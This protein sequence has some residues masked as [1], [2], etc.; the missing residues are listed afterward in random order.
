MKPANILLEVGVEKVMLTDFGLARTIDDASITRTGVIAG[1]PLYMS[2]EQSRGESVD[3]RSDLFSLGSVLYTLAT[4][5]T[6]FR[7]ESTY[8]IL[9]R[10]T[11]ET[12]R[13]LRDIVPQLPSWFEML[14][15]KLLAK[16]PAERF[17]S[18]S[19]VAELLE[20]CIAHLQQPTSVSLPPECAVCDRRRSFPLW[21][22]AAVATIIAGAGLWG[23]MGERES[24]T[25]PPQVTAL[26]NVPASSADSDW[27]ENLSEGSGANWDTGEEEVSALRRDFDQS[28]DGAAK[29]WPNPPP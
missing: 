21:A 4:G 17:D 25:Q 11:D 27:P 22:G 5:R 15:H 8:G 28:H 19:R 9:R 29:L 12:P 3:A 2:P 16:Q 6:P 14:V 26:P 7:A 23:M 13:P 1:T 24:D 20:G 10:L 18:A